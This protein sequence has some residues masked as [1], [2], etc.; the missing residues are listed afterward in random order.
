M[1]SDN[2]DNVRLSILTTGKNEVGNVEVFLNS[3]VKALNEI[4]VDGEII[5]I[6][7]GST[8]GTGEAVSKYAAEHQDVTIRLVTHESSMGITYAISE[9]AS[10]AKGELVCLMPADLESLPEDDIPLL[11]QAM[12]DDVDVVVGWRKDRGDGKLLASKLYNFLNRILFDVHLHDANWIKMVRRVKLMDLRLRSDWHRFLLPILVHRGCKVREV[13]TQWK[14][15]SYGS[16]NFG[17]RRFPVSLVDMLSVKLMLSFEER[18]LLLY[19]WLGVL[20]FIASMVALILSACLD[21][22][23]Q[24]WSISMVLFAVLLLTTIM[25]FLVGTAVDLIRNI[26]SKQ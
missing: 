11:Y 24:S 6:D 21:T 25:S 1:S 26:H 22:G 9:S 18:P 17:L 8:D 12:D 2:K 3:A 4:S 14:P 5:Y 16:S 23:S 20:S 7:D 15:R 10:L 13:V 19:G